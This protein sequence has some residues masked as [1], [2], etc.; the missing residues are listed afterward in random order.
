MHIFI[1]KLF[2]NQ[3]SWYIKLKNC[4]VAVKYNLKWHRNIYGDEINHIACRSLWLDAKD[5]LYRCDELCLIFL[6]KN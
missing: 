2:K 3:L 4:N 6:R 1:F 5:R